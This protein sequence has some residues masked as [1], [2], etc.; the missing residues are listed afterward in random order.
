M[1]LF[2]LI[3]VL[4]LIVSVTIFLFSSPQF[5][6]PP[7]KSE[8][9]GFEKL[10]YFRDGVFL[11]PTPT[12][13]EMDFKKVMS[14]LGDYI[15]GI[16]NQKPDEQLKVI[17]HD[18]APPVNREKTKVIWFGHSAFLLQTGGLNILIDPMLGESPSPVPFLG[19]K[20]F[21]E[22]LPI[23]MENLPPIDILLISHD[24]YDHLDYP[25][26]KKIES[27][28]KKFF[29]PLG[30]GAHL[31]SWGIDNDRIEEFAWWQNEEYQ[32]VKFTSAPARHFSGRGLTD[33]FSTLWCSWV[34][35]TDEVAIYFSGDGGYGPHFSEIG[36]RLGP[37]DFAM[38][39]CGQYD[40]RWNEIHMM[41]EETAI[42]ASDV[43]A[44]AFMPIH[45]GAFVLALH[46]WD[47]PVSRVV[48]KAKELDIQIRTPEIGEIVEIPAS[49]SAALNDWWKDEKY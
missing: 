22:G 9:S 1:G 26:I 28:V 25:T 43:Q 20:R 13:M 5:G 35:K 30:V 42:A 29:V 34:I 14:I 21:T 46:A 6:A 18:S 7:T 47:D 24:H 15:K 19:S 45:W 23:S 33:R 27:S 10:S 44:K 38:M 2:L 32:N 36:D 39:E 16:P 17:K 40:E 41:P 11:N 48:A 49:D 3:T 37:F 4:L 8:K 12:Q 31:R